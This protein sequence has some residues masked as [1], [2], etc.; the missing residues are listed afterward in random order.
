MD[1][2]SARAAVDDLFVGRARRLGELRAH[3]DGCL[4]CRA[5]YDRTARAFRALNGR[6]EQMTPEELLLFA[7]ALPEQ[8]P[9]RAHWPALFVGA[10]ATA[11]AAALVVFVRADPEEFLPRGG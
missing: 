5:H 10:L 9:A 2:S 7:P 1:H 4:E 3:L 8:A 6:P 11:A